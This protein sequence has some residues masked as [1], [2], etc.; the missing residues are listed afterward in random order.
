MRAPIRLSAPPH[1]T[2]W[3]IEWGSPPSPSP[4]GTF[5]E[6]RAWG[7][8]AWLWR[9]CGRAGGVGVLGRFS[10]GPGI[11]WV[12][13]CLG[14]SGWEQ[15]YP[16]V[17]RTQLQEAPQSW[18]RVRGRNGGLCTVSVAPS[19]SKISQ[20][21]LCPITPV[22]SLLGVIPGSV[23]PGCA[24]AVGASWCGWGS[25]KCEDQCWCRRSQGSQERT[26]VLGSGIIG[27]DTRARVRVTGA[28]GKTQ[29]AGVGV[30][31][32]DPGPWGPGSW[33][34]GRSGLFL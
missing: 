10:L 16:G 31:G 27:E 4:W 1:A 22:C 9:V 33:C 7:A 8:L 25:H 34:C 14:L 13:A 32:Q 30:T 28:T 24:S 20:P 17:G 29:C 23:S 12:W 11:S 26:H 19:A 2:P 21:V 6:G 18:F 15:L 3:A 5:S